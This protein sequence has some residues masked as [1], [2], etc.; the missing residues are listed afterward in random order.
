MKGKY[1]KIF[2]TLIQILAAALV[3]FWG[4]YYYQNGTAG[5]LL[6]AAQCVSGIIFGVALIANSL[7]SQAGKISAIERKQEKDSITSTESQAKVKVL[8]AKIQTLEK[9]LENALKGGK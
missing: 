8:E 2:L 4:W 6:G 7:K 1:M 3:I 5:L 9:A